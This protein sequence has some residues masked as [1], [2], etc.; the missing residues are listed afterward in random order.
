MS[1]CEAIQGLCGLMVDKVGHVVEKRHVFE[2]DMASLQ[3]GPLKA[4]RDDFKIQRSFEG[5]NTVSTASGTPS[6]SPCSSP[7]FLDSASSAASKSPW[8]QGGSFPDMAAYLHAR[9]QA[10][11]TSPF[12]MMSSPAFVEALVTLES[13]EVDDYLIDDCL[14]DMD[15]YCLQDLELLESDDHLIDDCLADMNDYCLQDL[16]SLESDDYLIDDCLADM[17]DYCLQDLEVLESDDYLI[18]DCWADMVAYVHI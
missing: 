16:E 8:L 6:S 11:G 15:E 7:R 13:L 1:C 18:D 17:N 12:V 4:Q 2:T 9:P 10:S 5:C 14:A 3:V